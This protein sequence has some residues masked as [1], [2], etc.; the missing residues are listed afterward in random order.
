MR[1]RHFQ[2]GS[3][4]SPFAAKSVPPRGTSLIGINEGVL[5]RLL[6][7]PVPEAAVVYH[8]RWTDEKKGDI[9]LM[10]A[11]QSTLQNLIKNDVDVTE[12]EWVVIMFGLFTRL[13]NAHENGLIHGDLKPSNGIRLYCV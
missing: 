12:V 2:C 7:S 11:H 8:E 5:E 9:I 3:C 10:N 1:D 13:A 4:G 6:K